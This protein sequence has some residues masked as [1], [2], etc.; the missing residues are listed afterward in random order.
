MTLFLSDLH[1]GHP[2]CRAGK[3]NKFLASQNKQQTIYLVGDAIDD[4][5]LKCWP[6]DHVA[7][8]GEILAFSRIIYLPGNHDEFMSAVVGLWSNA[9]TVHSDGFYMVGDRKYFVTH[10]HKY[11]PTMPLVAPRWFRRSVPC[12]GRF[13]TK[14]FSGFLK[15]R[16]VKA[17]QKIGCDGVICGHT[18][19]P[20]H[21]WVGELEYINCGDWFFSCTAVVERDGEFKLVE[22]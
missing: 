1:L 7:A 21:D 6:T 9:V 19:R 10:G 4:A 17:A 5:T 14:I 18:H 11:D 13:H 20:E 16:V 3:L 15:D 12:T 2:M 22:V 8:V